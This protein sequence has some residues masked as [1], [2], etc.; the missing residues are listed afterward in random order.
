MSKPRVFISSTFYDLRLVRLE[1][2]KFLRILGYEPV[3]NE[4]G[5]I[6]YGK[7]EALEN[8]CYKEIDNVDI[9]ISI[10]GSRFGSPSDG[11]KARSIS[12]IELKTALKNNKHVFI[13]IEKNVFIEYETYLLNKDKDIEY[14]YVDNTNI[15]RFIEEIKSLPNNNNIKEFETAD[16][17]TSYLREQFAGLMKQYFINEQRYRETSIL[18]DINSTADT[19]KKLVGFIQNTNQDKQE[20]LREIIKTSHPIVKT[21]KDLF[22]IKYKFYIENYDDLKNLL[23]ARGFEKDII[24]DYLYVRLDSSSGQKYILK[25]GEKVFDKDSNLIY[26]KPDDWQEEEMI[27]LETE[28]LIDDLPF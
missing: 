10:I 8:Y 5:D 4:T 24:D 16:D 17:I 12:N 14:K 1:L 21:L 23:L 13:F 9:L 7:M 11:D 25:I 20:G 6:P 28:T 2:D 3:R 19:L 15:Y 27:K 22:Q 26:Y 18:K